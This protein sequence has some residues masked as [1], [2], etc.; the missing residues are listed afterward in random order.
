MFLSRNFFPRAIGGKGPVRDFS[1]WCIVD[2]AGTDRPGF[3]CVYEPK[4]NSTDLM[5]RAVKPKFQ[6]VL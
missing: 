6:I 2:K 3:S 1:Y 4:Q 5:I